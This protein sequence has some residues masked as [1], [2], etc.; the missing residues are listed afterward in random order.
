MFIIPTLKLSGTIKKQISETIAAAR[1]MSFPSP[2]YESFL[3][4]ISQ[5]APKKTNNRAQKKHLVMPSSKSPNTSNGLA[6]YIHNNNSVI[7]LIATFC[8]LNG[9]FIRK[10]I[11]KIIPGIQSDIKKKNLFLI[12]RLFCLNCPDL[13]IGPINHIS[14]KRNSNPMNI[15]DKAL[16]K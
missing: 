13:I 4:M 15:N 7:G 14:Y 11:R 9:A 10:M 8:S 1:K 12:S 3:L 5:Q 16:A 6:L 2:L